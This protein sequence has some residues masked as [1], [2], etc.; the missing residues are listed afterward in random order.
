MLVDHACAAGT[1]THAAANTTTTATTARVAAWCGLVMLIC[2]ISSCREFLTQD[3]R[4][5]RVVFSRSSLSFALRSICRIFGDMGFP[6][7]W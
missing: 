3:T 6:P 4:R 1:L 2:S 5:G 7:V